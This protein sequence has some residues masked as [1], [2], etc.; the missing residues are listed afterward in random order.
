MD[1]IRRHHIKMHFAEKGRSKQNHHAESE[2]RELKQRW[3]I[4]MTE[5][6][7]PSRL[8]DYGLIYIGEILSIIAHGKSG[9]PGI[10]A[11]KGHTVDI[12]EWLDFEFYDCVWCWDEKGSDMTEEQ[13]L[14]GRWL[15][16]A[17]HVGSDMTYWILTKSGRVIARSTV[18]HIT[19]LDMQQ[20]AIQQLQQLFD[21]S[22]M[23]RF[24]DEQFVLMEPGLFYLEDVESPEPVDEANIPDDAEY[25]DMIHEPRP[26]VDDI[27]TYDRYL[28]AEVVI[29]RDGKPL[30]ARVVKRAKF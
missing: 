20:D 28:N 18:Q 14:I 5:H 10:E 21:E 17:H 16:I 22:I 8:W 6:H 15:G 3:K 12:S 29:N 2:I 27:D 9:C 7:V 11:V 1:I 24:T 23:E 30:R 4:R 19:T 25:G 13:H 26:D